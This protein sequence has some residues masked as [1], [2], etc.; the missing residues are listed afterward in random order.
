MRLTSGHRLSVSPLRHRLSAQVRKLQRLFV[1]KNMR[2]TSSDVRVRAALECSR[3]LGRSAM[4]SGSDGGASLMVSLVVHD[5]A[6]F[7]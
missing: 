7:Y 2:S 4:I 1:L 5:R 6:A 3:M